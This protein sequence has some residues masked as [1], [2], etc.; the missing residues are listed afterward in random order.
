MINKLFFIIILGSFFLKKE[1][2]TPE[3]RDKTNFW[4]CFFNLVKFFG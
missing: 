4:S 1:F 2:W 3:V